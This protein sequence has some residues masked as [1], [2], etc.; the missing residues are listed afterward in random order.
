M[1]IPDGCDIKKIE[2]ARKR[3]LELIGASGEEL[4]R[5]LRLH[6][7]SFVCDCFALYSS[8]SSREQQEAF[9]YNMRD[10]GVNALAVPVAAGQNLKE[11]VRGFARVQNIVDMMRGDLV[12]ALCADDILRARENN[13]PAIVF[14]INSPPVAGC[15]ES[16]EDE[17]EW[18][19]VF[20]KLGVR[21]MHLTYNRQNLIGSGCTEKRDNGLSYLG[22]EVIAKMNDIGIIVDAPHSSRRTVLD[23]CEVASKPIL[24]SHTLCRRLYDHCRGRSDEEIKAIAGTG[25][26]VGILSYSSFLS[27]GLGDINDMLDH[28]DYAVQL[29]GPEHVGIGTDNRYWGLLGQ[30]S[31]RKKGNPQ[32]WSNWSLEHRVNDPECKEETMWG[33]LTW[34]NWPY[35]TVGLLKRGYSDED[36]K[37]IIG[38]NYFRLFAECCG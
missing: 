3:A 21:A 38:G 11:C 22:A 31:G 19:E 24:S 18:L 15:L 37:K 4:E 35:F 27:A 36:I 2:A 25:G 16:S 8:L 30:P 13:R 26:L 1:N 7:E 6:E 23:A 34:T 9:L 29:V 14:E 12:K 5:A 33:S 32:W 10:S 17:L 20:W 28:I